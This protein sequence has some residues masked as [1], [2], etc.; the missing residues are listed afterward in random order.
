MAKLN[1]FP[2][3]G[4]CDSVTERLERYLINLKGTTDSKM[5]KE[6]STGIAWNS[7]SYWYLK[8]INHSKKPKFFLEQLEPFLEPKKNEVKKEDLVIDKIYRHKN[9]SI[10]KWNGINGGKHI[11]IGKLTFNSWSSGNYPGTDLFESSLEDAHWLKECIKQ[12]KFITKEEAM[13]TFTEENTSLVGRYVK[14]LY[15]N[16][17][18]LPEGTIG[19]VRSVDNKTLTTEFPNNAKHSIY[20]GDYFELMPLD[21]IPTEEIT[22]EVGKWYKFKFIFSNKDYIYS[23]CTEAKDG[24]YS[25]DI[26]IFSSNLNSNSMWSMSGLKNVEL[27][28]DLSVIQEFLT[29][30]PDYIELLG[31]YDAG[32]TGTIYKTSDNYPKQKNWPIYKS[33]QEFWDDQKSNRHYFRVSTKEAYELQSKPKDTISKPKEEVKLDDKGRELR[34]FQPGEWYTNPQHSSVPKYCR[35]GEVTQSKSCNGYWYNSFIFDATAD[36]GWCIIEGLNITQSNT[37]Y[38]I[39]MVKVTPKEKDS[40]YQVGDWV[41]SLIDTKIGRKKGDVLQIVKING[42]RLINGNEEFFANSINDHNIYSTLRKA[43]PEEIPK[44]VWSENISS[45]CEYIDYST[46]KLPIITT[47]TKQINTKLHTTSSIFRFNLE[48]EEQNPVE[49]QKLNINIFKNIKQ[50]LKLKNHGS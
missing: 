19:I 45:S 30:I 20:I 9:G 4:C 37:D 7:N 16:G 24:N 50:P 1:K 39:E 38:N 29:V 42:Y 48:K 10:V 17:L 2:E 43:R 23:K 12:D 22:F 28:T 27:L 33:W 21:Y 41:V 3:E 35:I 46:A 18:N 34:T 44:G 49:V 25:A 31:G 8:N 14:A 13:E 40:T 32:K 26:W 15:S 47:P 11:N 6:D 36:E 5:S